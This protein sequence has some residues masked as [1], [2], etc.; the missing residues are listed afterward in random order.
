MNF[1]S[2]AAKDF[3][4]Y[5]AN[6]LLSAKSNSYDTGGYTNSDARIQF[7]ENGT[8]IQALSGYVSVDVDGI[9][10]SSGSDTDYMSGYWEV[11][12]LPNNTLIILFY[13]T[14]PMMLQ[15]SPNGFLPFPVAKYTTNFVALPNGDGYKRTANQYC[16]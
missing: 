16:N 10:A 3:R 15:D 6:S 1:N 14:H 7:C 13:S 4:L 8:F 2:K 11:A 9:S 12:S 5:M